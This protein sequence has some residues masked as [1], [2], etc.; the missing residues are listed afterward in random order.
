M[1]IVFAAEITGDEKG[2]KLLKTLFQ[3]LIMQLH[4]MKLFFRENTLGVENVNK[5]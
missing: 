3:W 4:I 5:T 1:A 2:G